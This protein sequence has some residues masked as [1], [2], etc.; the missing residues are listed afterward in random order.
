[1]YLS[2]VNALFLNTVNEDVVGGCCPI[3]V[4]RFSELLHWH[5]RVEGL[6]GFETVS[7]EVSIGTRRTHLKSLTRIGDSV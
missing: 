2:D 5:A 1:M 6:M 7:E 4:G 3:E